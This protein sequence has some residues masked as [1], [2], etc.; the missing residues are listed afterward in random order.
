MPPNPD[1]TEPATRLSIILPVFNEAA[2]IQAMLQALAEACA[3]A[4][5]DPPAFPGGIERLVAD[6]GSSDDTVTLCAGLAERVLAAPRGRARQMNAGAAV[7][8]G[9]V[10]LFL[11]ADTRL[12][13][14]GLRAL[15]SALA[16]RPAACWG[17]YDVRIEGRSRWLPV[18]AQ[19][20]NWRSAGTGICTGDQ[21]IFV[22]RR[23][24]EQVGGFPDQPLMEDIELSTRLRRLPQ[25]WPV[26][27]REHVLTSGRR[28]DSRGAW[29]TIRLMWCL[30]WRY[31]RGTPADE[32][33]EAYR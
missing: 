14:D 16:E 27:L 31:W 8:S 5:V 29:S 18:I 21:A 1:S 28:W 2:G 17:R 32:L 9:T 30:R 22:R 12:P 19:M 15:A 25:G 7:A 24:F 23:A 13:A 26:R 3:S 10:L 11:H 6:G 33:A 20:M 4:Q